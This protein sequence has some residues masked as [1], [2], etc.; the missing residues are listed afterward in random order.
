MTSEREMRNWE[1]DAE[2]ETEAETERRRS[3]TLDRSL[4]FR[5]NTSAEVS[6]LSN[7]QLYSEPWADP[8]ESST[9]L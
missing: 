3:E 1:K 2:T 7:G 6:L 9:M 4:H 8:D 5:G